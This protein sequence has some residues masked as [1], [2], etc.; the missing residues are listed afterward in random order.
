MVGGAMSVIHFATHPPGETSEFVRQAIW[1]P[2]HVLGYIGFMIV[3]L[4]SVGWYSNY[5]SKLGRMGLLGFLLFFFGAATVGGGLLWGGAVFQSLLVETNPSVHDSI[6]TSVNGGIV[7]L[8]LSSLA[9]LLG[10]LIFTSTIVRARV[11]PRW[12]IWLL[13]VST[14]G[15]L[16]LLGGTAISSSVATT[17]PVLAGEVLTFGSIVGWGYALNL[18]QKD[19][20]TSQNP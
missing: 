2:T 19:S 8:V 7:I 3:V 1:V 11:P 15:I 5:S 9:F 16:L 6:V 13:V 4:G 17:G 12:G 10:Y 14:L 18:A 20:G